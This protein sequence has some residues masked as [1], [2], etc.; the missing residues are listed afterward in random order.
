MTPPPIAITLGNGQ[1][2]AVSLEALKAK[3]ANPTTM[4]FKDF[5]LGLPR[6]VIK[7]QDVFRREMGGCS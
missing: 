7:G 6:G 4:D 1:T 5:R 2:T 3:G